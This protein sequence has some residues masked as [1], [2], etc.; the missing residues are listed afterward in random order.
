MTQAPSMT[1]D[2]QVDDYADFTAHACVQPEARR[3]RMASH[4]RFAVILLLGLLVL[5]L[6]RAWDGG[7]VDWAALLPV[8]AASAFLGLAALAGLA[9]LHERLL[10]ALVRRSTRRMLQ[11]HPDPLFLGRHRLDFGPDGITDTAGQ[12]SGRL[13]WDAVSRIDET[14][15]HWYVMQD[16]TQGLVIPKRGQ[17]AATL[18]AVRAVLA[19]HVPGAR[20]A[21][22]SASNPNSEH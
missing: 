1:I 5:L 15:Q 6:A 8:Y 12:A 7:S 2:L 11:R 14:A 10:P 13:P 21:A 16:S 3:R 22:G 17:P 4:K 18:A 20:L 9:M 19:A